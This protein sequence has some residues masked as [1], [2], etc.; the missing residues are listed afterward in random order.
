MTRT[1]AVLHISKQAW[2]EIYLRLEKVD[3]LNIPCCG[4]IDMQGIALQASEHLSV[5][6]PMKTNRYPPPEEKKTEPDQCCFCGEPEEV[7]EIPPLMCEERS[8]MGF[9]GPCL[10]T[11]KGLMDLRKMRMKGGLPDDIFHRVQRPSVGSEPLPY[12]HDGARLI[13][14]LDGRGTE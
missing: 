13:R 4:Q 6:S 9:I 12:D 2:D 10:Y 11:P 14:E 7:V 5:E 1:Y 3:S 8:R